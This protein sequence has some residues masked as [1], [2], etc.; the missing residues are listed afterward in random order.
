MS[1]KKDLKYDDNSILLRGAKIQFL[2]I[3]GQA[4]T[5]R[6]GNGMNDH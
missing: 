6:M 1:W 4:R 5:V 2:N 3:E